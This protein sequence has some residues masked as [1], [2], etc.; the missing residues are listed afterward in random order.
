MKTIA[1]V[2]VLIGRGAIATHM[3]Y[4]TSWSISLQLYGED[5]CEKCPSGRI[6]TLVPIK[7]EMVRKRQMIQKCPFLDPLWQLVEGRVSFCVK[8]T[9]TRYGTIMVDDINLTSPRDLSLAMWWTSWVRVWTIHYLGLGWKTI[10]SVKWSSCHNINM[11]ADCLTLPEK[12][13]GW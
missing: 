5:T 12:I 2:H 1:R 6:T 10:F 7:Q 11:S 9:Q 13:F 8:S 4:L 3:T